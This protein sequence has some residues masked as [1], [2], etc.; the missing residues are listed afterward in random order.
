M[1]WRVIRNSDVN[2]LLRAM[3]EW[4]ELDTV[5]LGLSDEAKS[6]YAGLP[7][8]SGQVD[9]LIRTTK[10]SRLQ[11]ITIALQEKR[12]M[13]GYRMAKLGKV[14]AKAWIRTTFGKS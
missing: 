5:T 8:R 1:G 13:A 7:S 3:P 11:H 4:V 6:F 9:G 14:S 12:Q 2:I 10:S